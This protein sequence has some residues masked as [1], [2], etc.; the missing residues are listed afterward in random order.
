MQLELPTMKVDH[1]TSKP[2]L[3]EPNTVQIVRKSFGGIVEFFCR[4]PEGHS[5]GLATQMRVTIS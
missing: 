4:F 3:S 5:V 2:L 1:E